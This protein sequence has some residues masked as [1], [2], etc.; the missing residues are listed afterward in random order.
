M[1]ITNYKSKNVDLGNIFQ[2]YTSG[3]KANPTGYTVK[4]NN[5]DK[6]FCD[7]FQNY[8]VD[9][10]AALTEYN[11][12]SNNINQNISNIFQKYNSN[13][14]IYNN[15]D[16][17]E[18]IVRGIYNK[19]LFTWTAPSNGNFIKFSIT[20]SGGMNNNGYISCSLFGPNNQRY[21]FANNFLTCEFRTFGGFNFLMAQNQT[22]TIDWS[23]LETFRYL[24]GLVRTDGQPVIII[25]FVPGT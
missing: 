8:A 1:Q 13:Y 21:S 15:S 14:I 20:A 19:L 3:K 24:D 25:Y 9:A 18:T 7:I 23:T 16:G 12:V 10:K 4:I 6:D 11:F 17:T 5:I 22:V 2:K